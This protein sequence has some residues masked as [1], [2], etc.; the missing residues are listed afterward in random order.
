MNLAEALDVLELA[1][2]YTEADVKK[3]YRR[4]AFQHHPDR[5]GFLQKMVQINLAYEVITQP[6]RSPTRP[7]SRQVVY[8]GG[9][10]RISIYHGAPQFIDRW[11][12]EVLG[13]H[14]DIGTEVLVDIIRRDGQVRR[15]WI[16]VVWKGRATYHPDLPLS[17]IG[18]PI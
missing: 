11:G 9:W 17:F 18:I 12:V 1:P 7:E 3:A 5:G 14:R 16:R 15:R 6:G 2:G 13:L 10:R 8:T 4:L